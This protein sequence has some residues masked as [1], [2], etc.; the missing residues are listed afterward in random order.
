MYECCKKVGS[1]PCW[2]GSRGWGIPLLVHKCCK[3]VGGNPCGLGGGD[4]FI[5]V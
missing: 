4:P 3:L 5:S 1:T 2:F